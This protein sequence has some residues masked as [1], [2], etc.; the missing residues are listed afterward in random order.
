MYVKLAEFRRDRP[1]D[2]T[3]PVLWIGL[4][5]NIT[6]LF[7]PIQNYGDSARGE[8]SPAG[9]LSR[10]GRTL[11]LQQVQALHIGAVQTHFAQ[12]EFHQAQ[13]AETPTGLEITLQKWGIGAGNGFSV[14]NEPMSR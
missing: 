3:A 12:S 10:L 14:F 2:G 9:K 13:I 11:Q 6:R 8:I 1:N 7:Q 4:T 5:A